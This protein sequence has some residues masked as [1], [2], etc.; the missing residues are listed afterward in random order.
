VQAGHRRLFA[1]AIAIGIETAGRQQ[2]ID[3]D[4]DMFGG[5]GS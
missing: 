3:S 1:I 5:A 2:S 4:S